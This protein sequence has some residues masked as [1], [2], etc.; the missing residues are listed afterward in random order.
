MD[1]EAK[2]VLAELTGFGVGL[3]REDPGVFMEEYE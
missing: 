1:L 3:E 2:T